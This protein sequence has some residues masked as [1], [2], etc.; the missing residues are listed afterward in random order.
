MA[1]ALF[2][3]KILTTTNTG[4]FFKIKIYRR[5]PHSA[6]IK[7]QAA[8]YLQMLLLAGFECLVSSKVT[9]NYDCKWKQHWWKSRKWGDHLYFG[10]EIQC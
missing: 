7:P 9:K 6:L 10:V 2:S 4:F 3:K 1:K 8:A 5:S